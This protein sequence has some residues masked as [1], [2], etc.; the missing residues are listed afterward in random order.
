M[1]MG[2]PMK[3]VWLLGFEPLPVAFVE[4]CNQ[5]ARVLLVLSLHLIQV[6]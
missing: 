6:F 5:V 1:N 4:V 3:S 2:K